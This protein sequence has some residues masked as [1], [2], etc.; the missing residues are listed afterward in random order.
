AARGRDRI[1]NRSAGARVVEDR[2]AW[3]LGDRRPGEE[4]TD[5]VTVAEAAL[6]VDEEAAVGV[7]VPGDREIDSFLANLL[8]DEA[9][10][11]LE[12]RIRL[13]VGEVPIRLPEGGR[14]LEIEL[15]EQ[16]PD[17]RAGHA[18]AAVG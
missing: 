9:A 6:A 1:G 8:D 4:G 17:H 5:E 14:D 7:A 18:V 2:R 15:I 12:H 10:V 11:L 16:G 13:A 3:V